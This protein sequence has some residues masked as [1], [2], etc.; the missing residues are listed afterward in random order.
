MEA[1]LP[2][3]KVLCSS[4]TSGTV[5]DAQQQAR[6]GEHSS[7]RTQETTRA[8]RWHA[9]TGEQSFSGVGENAHYKAEVH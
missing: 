5:T 6:A 4:G 7:S 2:V 3:S 8:S 1:Y 9:C